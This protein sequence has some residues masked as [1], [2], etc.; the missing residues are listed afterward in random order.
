M[1]IATTRGDGG[2]TGLAGGI[3]IS[4]ASLRVDTYGTTDELKTMLGFA[5]SIC[6]DV[7]MNAWTEAIQRTLFRVGSALATP[8]ESR[9]QPPIITPEDIHILDMI[10]LQ[11]EADTNSP[12]AARDN[13]AA[14]LFNI[15]RTICHRSERNVVRFIESGAVIQ[16]NILIWLNR[17]SDVLAEF[18]HA[19]IPPEDSGL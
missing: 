14:A 18:S 7:Q 6:T 2:Q 10:L 9:K 1:S 17:L 4:K 16:P 11:L 8:P 13:S 3:R 5:R 12:H 19:L 15:A